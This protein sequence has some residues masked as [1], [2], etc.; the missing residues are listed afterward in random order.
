M[1]LVYSS[2]YPSFETLRIYIIQ[3]ICHV[4]LLSL[5]LEGS[6]NLVLLYLC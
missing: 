2:M 5:E 6:F 1:E 4:M 3:K